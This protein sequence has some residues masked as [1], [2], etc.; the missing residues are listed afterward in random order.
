MSYDRPPYWYP[1]F[2][3]LKLIGTGIFAGLLLVLIIALP[4]SETLTSETPD[5]V[6]VVSPVPDGE[7]TPAEGPD[8]VSGTTTPADDAT[9]TEGEEATGDGEEQ[10]LD[11]GEGAAEGADPSSSETG[12]GDVDGATPGEGVSGVEAPGTD[13][14]TDSEDSEAGEEGSTPAEGEEPAGDEQATEAED[15]V[16][17][18]GE[19][20]TASE[21]EA[22]A[23]ES[24]SDEAADSEDSQAGEEGST[25][26]EGEE[27]AGD[28]QATEAEDAVGETGE[29]DTASEEEAAAEESASDEAADSEDSQAG[30]EGSTPAEGEESAASEEVADTEDATDAAGEDDSAG[31]G[32]A[33]GEETT[34][35][36]TSASEG[37]ETGEESSIPA[38]GEEP[39]AGEEVADT[40]DATDETGEGDGAGDDTEAGKESS[41]PAEGEEPATDEEVA[42]TEDAT[43]ATAEDDSTGEE[44]APSKDSD[45]EEGL[46]P[47]AEP[48]DSDKPDTG[49]ETTTA[50]GDTTGEADAEEQQTPST[51]VEVAITEEDDTNTITGKAP[52]GTRVVLQ[53]DGEVVGET[54]TDKDGSWSLPLPEVVTPDASLQVVVEGKDGTVLSTTDIS[55]M[56]KEATQDVVAA[57][58]LTTIL[59]NRRPT[60]SGN[61]VPGSIVRLFDG[62]RKIAQKKAGKLGNWYIAVS[63]PLT[64]GDHSLRLAVI[65]DGKRIATQTFEVT[66]PAG[67]PAIRP[68]RIVRPKYGLAF[69]GKVIRGIAPKDSTLGIYIDGVLV[70]TVLTN[71]NG[72]WQYEFDNMPDGNYIL[73]V[74]ILDEQGN[75]LSESRAVKIEFDAGDPPYLLPITGSAS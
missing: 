73:R 72:R 25:P 40:E 16:G 1:G 12:E 37:S 27:P 46:A 15:A 36:E 32:E 67:A 42:D 68:P 47:G 53:R 66:I 59:N 23:E 14:A 45:S 65:S 34:P 57:N 70:D 50:D 18:T 60:F 63:Y 21:E 20:D 39:A 24:A 13:E 56:V 31:E 5:T 8:S 33:V 26:A 7:T 54:T 4:G 58:R 75:M 10:D 71:R 3:R 30:E 28:E 64:V 55:E 61:T 9:S 11:I 51:G 29:S 49:D 22:A 35:D 62:N 38:E 48:G 44:T 17:E 43:D 6:A 2:D 74:A 52:P 69:P 41:T 19:S